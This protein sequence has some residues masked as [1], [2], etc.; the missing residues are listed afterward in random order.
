[1]SFV[2]EKTGHSAAGETIMGKTAAILLARLIFA[3][4]FAMAVSFMLMGIGDTAG[5]IAAA[6][7]PFP[8]LLAWIAAQAVPVQTWR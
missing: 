6:G 8:L 5:Y 4:V 7:F 2:F 3:G 1:M